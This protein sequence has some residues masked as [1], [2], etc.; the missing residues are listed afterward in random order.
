MQIGR[1]KASSLEYIF[2]KQPFIFVFHFLHQFA[3]VRLNDKKGNLYFF[4]CHFVQLNKIVV[5]L[6]ETNFVINESLC[7]IIESYIL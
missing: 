6:I 4:K 1:I 2:R 3:A 5:T 7:K